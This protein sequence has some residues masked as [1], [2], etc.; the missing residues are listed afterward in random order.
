M[1]DTEKWVGR[2]TLELARE[3]S[4]PTGSYLYERASGKTV[5]EAVAAVAQ[6]SGYTNPFNV[7]RLAERCARAE[8]AEGEKAAAPK[9]AATTFH[10]EAESYRLMRARGVSRRQAVE[11]VATHFGHRVNRPALEKRLSEVE[12]AMPKNRPTVD[13]DAIEADATARLPELEQVRIRL[14]ADALIDSEIRDEYEQVERDIQGCR[15]TLEMCSIAR[16]GQPE[17]QPA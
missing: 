6:R 15:Q 9:P 11:R 13:L 4:T 14:A 17:K 10:P 5:E 12:Q 7:S 8:E 16:S 1:T 3:A 2:S